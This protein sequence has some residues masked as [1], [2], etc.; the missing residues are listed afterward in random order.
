MKFSLPRFPAGPAAAGLG[1]LVLLLNCYALMLIGRVFR[2][3][4]ERWWVP[5]IE[6]SGYDFHKTDYCSLTVP[7]VKQLAELLWPLLLVALAIVLIA[8][9][10]KFLAQLIAVVVAAQLV[11]LGIGFVGNPFT[12]ETSVF[13]RPETYLWLVQLLAALGCV[14]SLRSPG[15]MAPVSGPKRFNR[16]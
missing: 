4:W 2:T 11:L 7:E 1:V 13:S 9:K 12:F 3:F 10:R 15:L 8:A 5:C 14:P 6:R 16:S